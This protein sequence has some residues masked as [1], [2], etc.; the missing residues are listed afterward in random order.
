MNLFNTATIEKSKSMCT[1]YTLHVYIL[2][3]TPPPLPLYEPLGL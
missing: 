3:V 1:M 2:P